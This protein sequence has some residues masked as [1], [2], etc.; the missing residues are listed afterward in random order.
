MAF[1]QL[2]SSHAMSIRKSRQSRAFETSETIPVTPAR[3]PR[4][5]VIYQQS[6][7]STPSLSASVPFDWEAARGHKPPPYQ[8]PNA[9]RVR[10]MRASM[11]IGTDTPPS[12]SLNFSNRRKP[13]Q[14]RTIVR[15]GWR[16]W[17]LGLPA[18]WWL[19]FTMLQHDLPLPP[20]KT[21]GR[22]IGIALHLIHAYTKWSEISNLQKEDDGWG[23][24]NVQAL[25]MDEDDDEAFWT[26]WV[27]Q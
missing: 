10:R 27:C 22:A 3:T 13:R 15:S 9:S 18:Q 2:G 5:S 11:G 7:L 20:P 23:Q 19:K 4:H 1:T 16:Q 12:S 26:R 21:T 14:S 8:T 25:F 17:L 6:P 24:I